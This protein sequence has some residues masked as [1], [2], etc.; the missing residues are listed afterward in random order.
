MRTLRTTVL[1]LLLAAMLAACGATPSPPPIAEQPTATSLPTETLPAPTLTSTQTPAP[2]PPSPTPTILPTDTPAP[3]PE[4]AFGAP[5]GEVQITIVY[6]NTTV[7]PGLEAE[8]GFAAWID[9]GDRDILFDT[10]P[11]GPM[12]LGNL[13]QLGFDP[14]EVDLVILSH[15][16]GDHTGGLLS[17][18]QTGVQPLLYV[19]SGF[20]SSYK[21]LLAERAELVEVEG[22][23]EILP[24]LH[25]TGELWT[26]VRG[27]GAALTEQA[28]VIET[29]EGSVIITGCAHPGIVPIVRAAQQIAPGDVALVMGGFHLLDKIASAVDAAAATLRELGVKQVSPT[30]CTGEL[31]IA[32]F[33]TTYGDDYIEGGAGRV[34]SLGAPPPGSSVPVTEATDSL[35]GLSFDEF[36]DESYLQ[37]LLRSPETI[38]AMG[39]SE[40]L[41]QRN[42]RLDDLSDAHLR[43]TQQLESAVLDQ[44]RGYDRD[45]LSPEQALSYDLYEYYLDS[46]VQ[47]HRFA[48]HDYPLHHFIRSYHHDVDGLFTEIHP[49]GSVSDV[50]DYIVRLSRVDDQAAQFLEGLERREELGVIPPDF[51]VDLARQSL[52]EYLGLGSAGPAS[53]D[54]QK[55]SVYT[56][57][58]E[59]LSQI[60]GV[61]AEQA[62]QFREAALHEIEASFVPAFLALKDHL[63]H[64]ATIATP[65]AGAWKLPNGEAYYAYMLRLE[66]STELTPAEIHEIGLDEVRRIQ[67]EMREV[68]LGLGYPEEESL[69]QLM[70]RAVSEGGWFDISTPAGRDHYI[71]TIEETIEGAEQAADAV[72]DLRPAGEVIVIGGPTGGYYVPGAPD[73]S[74]PGSYHVSLGGQWRPRYAMPTVAYHETAPGHHFQIAIAQELDLPF[75]RR[76]VRFT[77][78]TEGWAMYAERL[79]SEL[80]LYDGDPYGNLGRLQYELLR[81]VRL[82]TDTGIH[83]MHW[84]RDQ[85][86]AYMD[87]AMG[88]PPGRFS[89]EVDRYVV[90]PGQ[91]TAYKIGMLKILNL[92]QQAMDRLGDQFNIKQFHNVV[93]GN[94]SLPLGLLERVVDQY[95]ES[96]LGDGS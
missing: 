42:D 26:S 72:F 6:D 55:L 88:A 62:Q 23:I 22:P 57:L 87:Q 96:L 35:E 30:H 25:S 18:L 85:A 40:D 86:R 15:E 71:A 59:A 83:A 19:P 58:A 90:L 43:G 52:K 21:R 49:L 29:S 13:A 50:E 11:G 76:D 74:R 56:R 82:V 63:D 38:T 41:G 93:L 27:S 33:A 75:P 68:L 84:S 2:I 10:G 61:S 73:G 32:R 34:Y 31:A 51:I 16:H 53:V 78:Y 80:G 24:G 36:L 28:L 17:L 48:Y 77:A 95:I 54:A 45:A 4:P 8:W 91:A 60:E 46:Q 1:L 37:L 9:Y 20:S 79:A 69:S 14:A 3:A 67:T 44:L 94:G 7:E 12:L 64:L 47:G 81:A 70:D 65:E 89:Y 92:R 39:L 66:T 5:P